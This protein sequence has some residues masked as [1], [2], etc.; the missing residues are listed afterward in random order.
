MELDSEKP[1]LLRD[2]C[3]SPGSDIKEAF[4]IHVATAIMA[5]GHSSG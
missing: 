2:L 5:V 3:H 1:S 4:L